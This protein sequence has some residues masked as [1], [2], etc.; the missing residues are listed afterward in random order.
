MNNGNYSD[1]LKQPGFFAFFCTQFLGAFNDNFLKITVSSFGATAITNG[2][3]LRLALAGLASGIAYW[4][5]P[6][7]LEVALVLGVILPMVAFLLTVG[8]QIVRL[9][10]EMV[11]VLVSWPLM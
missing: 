4:I 7:G 5:R 8:R 9:V 10:Y 2:A 3:P 1:T 6:E 11:C